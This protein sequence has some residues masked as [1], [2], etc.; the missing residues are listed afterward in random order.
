[1]SGVFYMHSNA[2][3]EHPDL[4]FGYSENDIKSR[5]GF[6]FKDFLHRYPSLDRISVAI[7]SLPGKKLLEQ[8]GEGV[9]NYA[10]PEPPTDNQIQQLEVGDGQTRA[11]TI[12]L[13]ADEFCASLQFIAKNPATIEQLMSCQI[14]KAYTHV[15][16]LVIENY[17]VRQR[18]ASYKDEFI[19]SLAQTIDA[20]DPYTRWHSVRVAYYAVLLGIALGL[21]PQEVEVVRQGALLHDIG[22]L[23]VP[24]K[25][26]FKKGRLSV[27]EFNQIK[28]HP[29]AGA[30][31]VKSRVLGEVV[32][33]VLCHHERVDGSGYPNGL[34]RRDIPQSAQIVGLTDVYEALI[35]NRVY[36]AAMTD[37]QARQTILEKPS[38]FEPKLVREFFSLL[39]SLGAKKR[40]EPGMHFSNLKDRYVLNFFQDN[41]YTVVTQDDL[42]KTLPLDIKGL[43]KSLC[44][45]NEQGHL[46]KTK[47]GDT[48]YYFRLLEQGSNKL[49][50]NLI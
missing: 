41:P 20:R 36:R 31:I 24:E 14:I 42:A 16:Q 44:G 4:A 18:L 1:M 37:I 5:L 48:I 46:C 2:W 23:A 12:P 9:G 19:H 15:I 17:E 6:L 25:I 33:I 7:Y 50:E 29:Q 22:K 49:V 30:D 32:P 43:E 21:P 45:L 10:L 35:S 28:G 3:Q 13:L 11:L 8:Y 26:L 47:A 34:R 39:D 38:Q 40:P 27:E